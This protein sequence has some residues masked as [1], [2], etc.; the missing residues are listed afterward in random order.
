VAISEEFDHEIGGF[1]LGAIKFDS[2][3][4]D[5]FC[6]LTIIGIVAV[7]N[8]GIVVRVLPQYRAKG[9]DVSDMKECLRNGTP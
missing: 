6:E 3:A 4:S 1:E 7:R 8:L 2:E 5:Q 9:L